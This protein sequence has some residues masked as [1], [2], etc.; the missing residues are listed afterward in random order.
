MAPIP[1]EAT[2]AW[3]SQEHLVCSLHCPTG[4]QLHLPLTV[5][6]QSLAFAGSGMPLLSGDLSLDD[7]NRAGDQT[8]TSCRRCDKEFNILFSRARICNHCGSF[9]LSDAVR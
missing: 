4:P 7:E 2:L 6:D 1:G 5:M 9:G 3:L 8:E